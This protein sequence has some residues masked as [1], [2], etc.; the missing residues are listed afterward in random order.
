MTILRALPQPQQEAVRL[1]LRPFDYVHMLRV[2]RMKTV[3]SLRPYEE[4]SEG[5]E[6][7]PQI[8]FVPSGAS[9]ASPPPPPKVTKEDFFASEF[10]EPARRRNLLACPLLAITFSAEGAESSQ[11]RVRL[12]L[13]HWVGMARESA[14]VTVLHLG[15]IRDT[16]LR[17]QHCVHEDRREQLVRLDLVA[18]PSFLHVVRRCLALVELG[19]LPSHSFSAATRFTFF[20]LCKRVLRAVNPEAQREQKLLPPRERRE[21]AILMG[22]APRCDHCPANLAQCCFE[23]DKSYRRWSQYA[24]SRSGHTLAEDEMTLCS[25]CAGRFTHACNLC[26]RGDKLTRG[27]CECGGRSVAVATGRAQTFREALCGFGERL[28]H[29]EARDRRNFEGIDG[30]AEKRRRLE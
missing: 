7:E 25:R 30:P 11:S 14:A 26:R 3:T 22:S 4:E 28:R 5:E 23:W 29:L 8:T 24:I 10:E 9:G 27:E 13:R 6:E 17:Y 20:K 18:R 21:L 16:S 19:A 1:S 12:A 15:E 2:G